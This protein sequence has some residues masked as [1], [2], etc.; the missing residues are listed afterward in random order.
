MK[1]I[2]KQACGRPLCVVVGVM[3]LL[4]AGVAQAD[5]GGTSASAS[6]T[7]PASHASGQSVSRA[8]STHVSSRSGSSGTAARSRPGTSSSRTRVAGVARYHGR[9]YGAG[10]GR[11]YPGY[12]YWGWGYPG[13]YLGLSLGYYGGYP[14]PYGWGG[15]YRVPAA[16]GDGAYGHVVMQPGALDLNVK[17]KRAEVYVNG[18]PI[19]HVGRYD[20]FPG[21]LWLEPG[22]YELIFLLNGYRT[23]RHEFT[24]RPGLIQDVRFRLEKGPTQSVSE[25]SR[26][27]QEL[28]QPPRPRDRELW[29][30][31]PE[32]PG[33][34]AWGGGTHQGLLKL[35]IDPNEAS[36]YLD[37][38]PIG[39]A[40]D[41]ERRQPGIPVA[42]GA[43]TLEVVY[44]GTEGAS[45]SFTMSADGL[46]SLTVHLAPET[47]AE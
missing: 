5:G 21:Y 26:P 9:H 20:G 1:S 27:P 8:S 38:Q 41:L 2:W 17:P 34:P 15:Y 30:E 42:P 22:R 29:R 23:A 11:Y 28:Q 7:R 33:N 37:G 12:P 35:D 25:L 45:R 3:S 19:G 32:R 31:S 14:W 10:F 46:V 18:E 43:H 13:Y 16:Y 24:V 44:P 39:T 4:A 36:V 47:G 40:G 6:S